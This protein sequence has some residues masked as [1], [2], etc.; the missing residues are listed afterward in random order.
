M[1]N[2][3]RT[4]PGAD[5]IGALLGEPVEPSRD[6]RREPP[7]AVRLPRGMRAQVEA[8]AQARGLTP[9][10]LCVRGIRRELEDPTDPKEEE[11]DGRTS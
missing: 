6:T 7:L 10:A 5:A 11:P 9:N 8:Q 2:E 4:V 1:V 3:R